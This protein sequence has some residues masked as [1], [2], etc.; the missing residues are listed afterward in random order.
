MAI[1]PAPAPRHGLGGMTLNELKRSFAKMGNSTIYHSDAPL[2]EKQN[3]KPPAQ[4]IKQNSICR[5]CGNRNKPNV[6]TCSGCANP[7]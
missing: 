2:T 4:K 5:Y 6:S 7:I 3:I 1:I